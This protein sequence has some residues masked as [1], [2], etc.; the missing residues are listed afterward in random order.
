[1]APVNNA[2]SIGAFKPTYIL[3]RVSTDAAGTQG[4]SEAAEPVFSPDG[5]KIAFSSMASNLVA[6]DSIGD[7]DI[8]IKDLATGAIDLVSSEPDIYGGSTPVFS[9]DGSKIAF[10]GSGL[11]GS[12][13]FVKDIVTGAIA[14]VSTSAAGTPANGGSYDLTFSPDGSKIAFASPATNLVAGDTNGAYDIFVKDLTTGAVTR[15]S[16]DAAGA[17]GDGYSDTPVFSPDGN[18]IAF[19]SSASNLV[20]G[21]TNNATDVFVKDLT[22]GTVTL[23]SV[24]GV[25]AQGNLASGTPVF[26]PDG[27]KVAF[28]SGASNL[29]PGDTNDSFDIFVKDLTTGAITR[30]SVNTAGVQANGHSGEPV[31]SPEGGRIAFFSDASNLVAG[32]T[33]GS[34]D[35]FVMDLTTGE[36]S[37]I[38]IGAAGP[39]GNGHSFQ[40]VFSPDGSSIAFF[41]L[42]PNLVAGDTNHTS[43]IFLGRST[44]DPEDPAVYVENAAPVRV[45]TQP[46]TVTDI[47]NSDFDG[48]SLTV[49]L[50]AGSHAG[51]SLTLI[52]SQTAGSGI[53]LSGATVNYYGTAIGTLSG[54]GTASLSI[55]LNAHADAVAVGALARAVGFSSTS[56]DPTVDARTV[57]FTLVDGSG[58]ANGGAD[59][60]SFT[61]TVMVTP[62]NDAPNDFNGDGRSDIVWR[63][64]SGVGQIW[65]MDGATILDANSLGAVPTTWDVAGTGDFNA[66]GKADLLWRNDAG[67]AQIWNMDDG[68]IAS[69]HAL[70]A[71]PTAWKLLGTG[72]FNG[73]GTTDLLWRHDNGSVQMW[74]MND[75]AIIDT[76][77]L[78]VIPAAW[79]LAGTG[80]FNGDGKSDLLWR[81]DSGVAQIW[82]MDGGNVLSANSLGAI[83]TTWQI[84]GIG[85]FNGDRMS[86][87]LWRSDS[88]VAQVWNMNDATIQS[89]RALGL[90]PNEWKV[91]AVGD[92]NGDHM[93]DIIWRNDS[94]L[95]QMWQM[96][97]GAIAQA[98][99]LGVVPTNW[100]IIA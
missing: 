75:G 71:I 33:N 6:G 99:S 37:R 73:D 95:T 56:D 11:V 69:T 82:D 48:G 39:E 36:V 59:T 45:A 72:D 13:I 46:V 25:G 51:D 35:I 2:P 68:A 26:S 76:H 52:V 84:A 85:D 16:V 77:A 88:G 83:P 4:N 63:H 21:D 60:G 67:V 24:N 34:R 50:T 57:T 90:I 81:N 1:M 3:T 43:D 38:S 40:L 23:V 29:V 18:K 97:D 19:Q 78:G 66:D 28:Q 65:D 74:D 64:D 41:S 42:A 5:S 27:N 8:F 15:V 61:Q 89:T 14:L 7:Y 62:V 94:G 12:G 87:I 30:V 49:A 79:K 55:A 98:T 92:Y 70:G 47:D 9:P 53:E 31:F 22:T 91:G 93:S 44:F 10:V 80:D 20:A 54:S 96:N 86:D 32:D 100:H 17:E 58:T